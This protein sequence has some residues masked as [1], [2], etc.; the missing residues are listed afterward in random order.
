MADG[1]ADLLAACPITEAISYSW[2]DNTNE[3][4]QTTTQT[5][6]GNPL[7]NPDEM[8]VTQEECCVNGQTMACGATPAGEEFSVVGTCC[9]SQTLTTTAMGFC[10]LSGAHVVN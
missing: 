4:T 7:P 2:D 5:Q 6:N 3:C 10:A 1:D 8:V 9:V